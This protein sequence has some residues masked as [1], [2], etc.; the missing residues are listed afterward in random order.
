MS[1]KKFVMLG[2]TALSLGTT[3]AVLAQPVQAQAATAIPA[4]FR[5]TWK[6]YSGGTH[7]TLKIH[8]YHANFDQNYHGQHDWHRIYYKHYS[9][10]TYMAHFE[11]TA[12]PFGITYK[13]SHK[14]YLVVGA[15]KNA[16]IS[17]IRY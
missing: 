5:H 9:K 4:R 17:L 7:Y 14:L 11:Y 8:K 6:G 2:V 15:G 10:N 3:G 13:N 1:V 12:Q 16:R